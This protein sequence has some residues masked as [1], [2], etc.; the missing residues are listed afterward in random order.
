MFSPLR[1]SPSNP[2]FWDGEGLRRRIMGDWG[3]RS[4]RPS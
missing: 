4:W 1:A 3:V 2:R